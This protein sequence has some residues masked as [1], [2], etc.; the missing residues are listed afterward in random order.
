MGNYFSSENLNFD[1]IIDEEYQIFI[2]IVSHKDPNPLSSQAIKIGLNGKIK[3]LE[4]FIETQ[5]NL[6]FEFESGIVLTLTKRNN[7]IIINLNDPNT[8]TNIIKNMDKVI[9][10]YY[11]SL[12]FGFFSFEF[13]K[14]QK[15]IS[16]NYNQ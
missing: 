15:F 1:R 12:N 3:R 9:R 14:I 8:E 6:T 11:K 4:K 5:N 10:L 7:E 16:I 13:D 2:G